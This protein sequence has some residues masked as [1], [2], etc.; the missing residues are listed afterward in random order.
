MTQCWHPEPTQRPNFSLILER[1]GYCLQDP[2]VVSS[3]LPIFTR[4]PSQERDQTIMRPEND[5]HCIEVS[6][7]QQLTP[8]DGYSFKVSKVADYLIPNNTTITADQ[9]GIGSTSSVDK[10]LPDTS[11]SWETSFVIPQSKSTQPLLQ[12]VGDDGDGTVAV[13][14][15][16]F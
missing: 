3:P 7:R 2:E 1:L 14:V 11:D 4:P 16:T 10:L 6:Y 13:R 9:N 12:D 15:G 8:I 5:D